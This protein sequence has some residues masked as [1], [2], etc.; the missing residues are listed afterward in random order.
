MTANEFDWDSLIRS[1]AENCSLKAALFTTYDRPNERLL[2]ENL[3]PE[4]LKLDRSPVTEGDERK[5]FL[6]ELDERLKSAR[7]HGKIVIV[8]STSRDPEQRDPDQEEAGEAKASR[9]L[10]G[11]IWRSVR[12]L[13][14]GRTRRAVQHAK[15]WLLHWGPDA[16][17]EQTGIEYLEIV[18]SSAN[19]T[20]SAFKDQIQAAWRTVLKLEAKPSNDREKGWGVLPD[21]IRELAKSADNEKALDSFINLLKRANCP[22]DT[23]FVASVPGAHAPLTLKQTP[24]GMAGLKDIAGSGRGKCTVT[25]LSPFV[26]SWSGPTLNQWCEAIDETAKTLNLLWLDK[27]CSRTE[28]EK[29]ILPQCTVEAFIGLTKFPKRKGKLLQLFTEMNDA[30]NSMSPFHKEHDLTNDTRWNHSK[31]Y[32]FTRGNSRRM[33]LTSANFSPAAWGRMNGN[34]NLFIDN[35]EL[36]VCIAPPDWPSIPKEFH[37]LPWDRVAI[38][39]DLPSRVPA[40]ITWAKA[41][42]DGEKVHVECRCESK[43]PLKATIRGSGQDAQS[44]VIRLLRTRDGKQLHGSIPWV[45]S[46]DVPAWAELTCGTQLERVPVFDNRQTFQERENSAPPGLDPDKLDA[47]RDRLLFEQYGGPAADDESGGSRNGSIGSSGNRTDGRGMI[48]SYDVPAFVAA[49]ENFAIVDNWVSQLDR[50]EQPLDREAL[51]DDGQRLIGA[52]N[53]RLDPDN[54]ISAELAAEELKIRLDLQ[55]ENA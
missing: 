52:F 15:L 54:A 21:F 5:F 28:I 11:W 24:W 47:M 22:K 26:G 14:V 29:W 40:I 9:D 41:E 6:L 10:Y 35:F 51:R 50:A 36:G 33:L 4:L 49:R 7:L 18:V 32:L 17:K 8:S 16:S 1:D 38:T 2:V 3:L 48:D 44:L 20:R 34:G 12:H 55:K 45:D 39:S 46:K 37:E 30:K 42:W 27:A 23:T 25:V 19:L 53:R 13:T 31:L 43:E